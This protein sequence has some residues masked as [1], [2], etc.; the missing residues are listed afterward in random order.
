[1]NFLKNISKSL[2]YNFNS[3]SGEDFKLSV[4]NTMDYI[5]TGV[6][7]SGVI[8]SYTIIDNTNLVS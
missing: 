4:K 5:L 7:D 1:M 3:G 8:R 2:F 6:I